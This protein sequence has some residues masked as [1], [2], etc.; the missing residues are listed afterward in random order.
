MPT[1]ELTLGQEVIRWIQSTCRVPEGALVGQPIRL[2][3]W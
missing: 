1:D 3:D 2:M